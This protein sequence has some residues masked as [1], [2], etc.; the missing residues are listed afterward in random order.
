M[1]KVILLLCLLLPFDIQAIST[2]EGM[3]TEHSKFDVLTGG[4]RQ[5]K[6]TCASCHT[7]GFYA[8]S[9]PIT[10][11]GCH[12]GAR[13]EAK[14]LP[15]N[16]VPEMSIR[17]AHDCKL[18]HNVSNFDQIRKPNHGLLAAMTCKSCHGAN[19]PGVESKRVTHEK[20]TAIDCDDSGC[21][22]TN[23]FDK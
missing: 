9:A 3:W 1:W 20:A 22:N 14:R 21:H 23:T 5:G 10:C 6:C 4:H 8:G 7:G 17:S 12:T 15:T 18:C 19:Y 16:H 11:W 13:P 2:C